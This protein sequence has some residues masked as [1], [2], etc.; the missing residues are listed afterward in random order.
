MQFYN[1]WFYHGSKNFV[2]TSL[3]NNSEAIPLQIEI[4][5]CDL[6]Q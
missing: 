5:I 3:A 2:E 6:F 4:L 1:I